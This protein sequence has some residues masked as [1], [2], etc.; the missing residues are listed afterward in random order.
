M[1]C[2]LGN[3]STLEGRQ[4]TYAKALPPSLLEGTET[5]NEIFSQNNRTSLETRHLLKI[6]RH[7]SYVKHLSN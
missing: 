6:L 4:R 3:G 1:N 7:T 2:V 5:N